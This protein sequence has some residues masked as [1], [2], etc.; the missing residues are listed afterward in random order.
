MTFDDSLEL[1]D[2]IALRQ[3][4]ELTAQIKRFNSR[5]ERT[6]A[7]Q[8]RGSPTSDARRVRYYDKPRRPT[9]NVYRQR[10]A[11]NNNSYYKN[12]DRLQTPADNQIR[13][14]D[15]KADC[16][17][18][19]QQG[20]HEQPNRC[21]AVYQLCYLCSRIGHFARC[22]YGAPKESCTQAPDQE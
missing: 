7:N 20:G 10:E 17:R 19:G 8:V 15:E 11:R 12:P 1:D 13:L 4:R 16:T 3:L 14:R 9:R 6:L 2:G 22:C 5:L 18:C 21:R